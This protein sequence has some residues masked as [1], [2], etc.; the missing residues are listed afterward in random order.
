MGTEFTFYDYVEKEE[1][2]IHAWLQ[3]LPK[4]VKAKFTNWLLHLEGVGPGEWKRP[5]VDTLTGDCDGLFEIRV[6]RSRINYRILGCHETGERRPTLLHG[7]IK[8]G[9]KV[10]KAECQTALMRKENVSGDLDGSR[11]VH[12]YS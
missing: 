9:A 10:P 8:P 7:F 12:D 4:S 11:E 5:L 1:N 2:L 6:E 3:E